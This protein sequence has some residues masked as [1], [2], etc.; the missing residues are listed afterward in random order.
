M[1]KSAKPRPRPDKRNRAALAKAQGRH[2][3]GLTVSAQCRDHIL[4]AATVLPGILGV[5]SVT[6][7]Q[8]LEWLVSEGRKNL[9][10]IRSAD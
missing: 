5:G 9:E 8:A 7:T 6:Q 3:L 10:K 1:A 4:D 2:V